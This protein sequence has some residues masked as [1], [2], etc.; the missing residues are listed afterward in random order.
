MNISLT[1]FQNRNG[2]ILT[3]RASVFK[4]AVWKVSDYT[5]YNLWRRNFVIYQ[6]RG[7][8]VGPPKRPFKTLSTYPSEICKYH[9]PSLSVET[10]LKNTEAASM[11]CLKTASFLPAGNEPL[12]GMQ[13]S[14]LLASIPRNCN[15]PLRWVKTNK[16][17]TKTKSSFPHLPWGYNSTKKQTFGDPSLQQTFR[18]I[19]EYLG[20]YIYIYIYMY[21]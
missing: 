18:I 17:Q 21:I 15:L 8:S 12:A 2:D 4:A 16:V 14:S 3:W 5:A 13:R 6:G 10:I 7:R 20:E 19:H 11:I 9:I 1:L